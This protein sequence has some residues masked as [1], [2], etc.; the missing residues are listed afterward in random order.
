MSRR[1]S[2]LGRGLGA[3]IP[4]AE[5]DSTKTATPTGVTEVPLAS[6]T[7]NPHQPR[8]SIRDQDVVELVLSLL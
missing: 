1:K 7:P 8:L 5:E 6:I 4:A 3:L 2:G